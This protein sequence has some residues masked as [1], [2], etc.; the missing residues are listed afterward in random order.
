[1]TTELLFYIFSGIALMSGVMVITVRN[2]VHSVLF[3]I[4]SFVQV[5]G[6]LL[7]LEAEFIA[8]LLI[9]VYVGA[10]S[11]LFLFVIMMLD[12]RLSEVQDEIYKYLPVGGLIGIIFFVEIFTVVESDLVPLLSSETSQYIGWSSKIDAVTNAESLGQLL[13]THYAFF[14]L[15]AGLILLVAMLGAIVLTMQTRTGVRRQHIYQQVS[16]DFENAVFL[17]TG[18]I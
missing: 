11:V 16:R 15:V 8:M 6:L 1:M 5:T 9:I 3:L 7:L 13:Y 17:A 2:P 14:F 10:T 4:L 12:I 18:K